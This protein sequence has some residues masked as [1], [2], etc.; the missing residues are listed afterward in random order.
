MAAMAAPIAPGK[1][2]AWEAWIAELKGPRKAEFDDMNQR[3]GLTG[4]RVW[5][6]Q[7][8][9]GHHLAIIVHDGP[10][11]DAFMGKVMTSDHEFDAWFRGNVAEVHGM[12]LSAPPPPPAE[13]RL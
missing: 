13:Q 5:L 2:D 1:L 3:M 7:T 11:A 10:G 6:Q 8:P 12:D 9:D 4:H